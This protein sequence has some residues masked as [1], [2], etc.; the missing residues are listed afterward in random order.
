MVADDSARQVVSSPQR[1]ILLGASNLARGLATVVQ[2]ARQTW[3]MPLEILAASGHGR[4]YG[5]RCSVL[6]RSLPG[7]VE[8][9]LWQAIDERRRVQPGPTAALITDIG[10][11]LLYGSSVSRIA[12]W[13]ETCLDRLAAVEARTILTLL[14]PIDEASLPEWKFRLLRS[15]FYPP[16]RLNRCQALERAQELNALLRALAAER[17]LFLIEPRGEWYGFD[18]IHLRRAAA[19]RAWGTM[20]APWRD[21]AERSALSRASCAQSWQYFF[22]KPQQRWWWGREHR[23]EQPARRERDGTALSLY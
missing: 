5:V 18:R 20:L 7:I 4:S 21:A 1:V 15:I 14:P 3:Q 9:G 11:D 17:G 10:N 12:G 6:G 13:V 22:L 2:A 8:C 19:P 23:G 16:S